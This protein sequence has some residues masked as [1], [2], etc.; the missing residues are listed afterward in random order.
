MYRAEKSVPVHLLDYIYL[1]LTN[2]ERPKGSSERKL[3]KSY[4]KIT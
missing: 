4:L 2:E 3:I 1:R